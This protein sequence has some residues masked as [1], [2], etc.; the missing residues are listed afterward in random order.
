[1]KIKSYKKENGETAYKFLLYAGYVNGKRKYIRREGF[2]TKQAA[3]ETLIS[4]QAE[5]DKPKSSMTFGALTD[6][7][8]KEYEKTVQCS[9]YLKTERN[10]NKHILPKLDKVKIGDINPLLIQRLTE[11]WCNDLK[12]GGKI[13]GLVR[14]ILNLA[15][16][17]GYINNNPALPITPPKIKRR[18]KMNNNFYTLDQL[19]QFLEL[20]E[21][22]DNIE[23]IA[24]FRLLAFT[25][26]RKGEL[27][28]LTWD[29]LN[30]NTLSINKAVTRT[31]VGLE[32]DVTKTKSSDRLISLDDETLEILLELHET[33]PTSTLMFQSESG[34]I[35]TP[36]LPRKW[37]LQIIKGT[38]LPQIT[39]H[40]F[41]HTH[42]S[43]LF[44]SGL[45]LKQVQ[46][47][48]GHGD[49]QTTMNVYTHITQ[50][51][52]DDI[53]TKFNQFVTN[54]QLD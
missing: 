45:S 19:K 33:F 32:I 5:L 1:M 54:K 4:L 26:I 49:L 42:A 35:M 40:G 21:K 41:R 28:A 22:T 50:S 27:L 44:E 15:V 47:R 11:E 43:L 29:D 39:I 38:D 34:G 9:T 18:R 7:W 51:A 46:H 52:I 31:Q 37:L 17:Y 14:N 20:V 48:L 25:G 13:L 3:R 10:I 23:K 6:Q 8:L 2:K 24:L 16:R 36:S 53:G 30:G 12:Y